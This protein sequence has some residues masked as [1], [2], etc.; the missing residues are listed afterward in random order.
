MKKTRLL[1]VILA[2]FMFAALFSGCG[3][4]KAV[5]AAEDAIKAIGEISIDSGEAIANA[6]KLYGILTDSEK[7]NVKNRLELVDAR[8]AF[9]KLQGEMVYE[10][11]KKAYEKLNDVADLCIKGM[12]DIYGAWYFGIYKASDSTTSNVFDNMAKET[13]HLSS[14]DLKD[15]ADYYGKLVGGL[16]YDMMAKI[17]VS[18]KTEGSW[19]Y[20]LYAAESAI[21]LK[22][23]YDTINS[24]MDE[25]QNILQELT[26][27]Y[28]DYTYYPK[29]KDYYSA[30][31]SYV[32]FFK[33]PSGSFKMLSDTV[34]GYENNIRTYQSDVG[35]LFK[36]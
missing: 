33:S 8:E 30:V 36:K 13:P 12:D 19:Q 3:K 31:S 18:T 17:M 24:E 23:D 35:F 21:T 15:G 7:S 34:N 32:E 16:G 22:G 27:T 26:T 2:L 14:Q 5:S 25:A 20:C 11:A 4:S 9:D 1:S 10:N 29:L 6:E 28:D